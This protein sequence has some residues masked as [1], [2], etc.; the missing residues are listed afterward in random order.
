LASGF[1]IHADHRRRS[2]AGFFFSS[3]VGLINQAGPPPFGGASAVLFSFENC[4]V[5][6]VAQKYHGV[7]SFDVGCATWTARTSLPSGASQATAWDHFA[8]D[9]ADVTTLADGVVRPLES[10]QVERVLG[11]PIGLNV[12]A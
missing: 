12:A 11:P 3:K 7:D 8:V 9:D 6:L 4:L 2:G 5:H 1:L 10:F